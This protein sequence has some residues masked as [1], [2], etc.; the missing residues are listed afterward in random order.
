MLVKEAPAIRLSVVALGRATNR[1][2]DSLSQ[3]DGISSLTGPPRAAIP[4]SPET[5]YGVAY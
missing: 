2:N 1:I 3:G 4:V 5:I